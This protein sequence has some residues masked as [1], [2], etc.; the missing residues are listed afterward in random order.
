MGR[1]S[2]FQPMICNLTL[3][4]NIEKVFIFKKTLID[5]SFYEALNQLISLNEFTVV[6]MKNIPILCI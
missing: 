3:L 4:L 1:I 2:L 5:G 6:K